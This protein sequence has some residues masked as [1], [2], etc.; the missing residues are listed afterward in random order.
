MDW[1]YII[2]SLNIEKYR[3]IEHKRRMDAKTELAQVPNVTG[4]ISARIE[5]LEVAIKQLGAEK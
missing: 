4:N 3:L 2:E 5:V 1:E